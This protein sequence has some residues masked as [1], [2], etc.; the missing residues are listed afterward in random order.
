MTEH[1][2]Y[3]YSSFD[4]DTKTALQI[5]YNNG[6]RKLG[7]YWKNNFK[8]SMQD[9]NAAKQ[10]GFEI[11]VIHGP[12][13]NTADIW[14]YNFKG[15]K[16]YLLLKK[17][18]KQMGKFNIKTLVLHTYDKTQFKPTKLGLKR[19]KNLVKLCKRNNVVLAVENLR[20]I[21]HMEYLLENIN[22]DNFKFCL[23]FGHANVWQLKPM[24]LM[25][26][27][28][29]R[30]HTVHISDNDGE[31]DYHL[32]PGDGTMDWPLLMEELKKHYKGPL[33]LEID[34]FKHPTIKYPDL[35]TYLK[36]AVEGLQM[37][38]QYF[39]K[40][41]VVLVFYFNLRQSLQKNCFSK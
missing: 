1:G 33:M 27:H 14:K 39:K 31:K 29:S 16:Y 37:L 24:Q 6:F 19:F 40:T 38:D 17:Y 10:V 25:Q 23:D 18:I 2:I 15:L 3:F 34:N 4:L 20:T 12:F 41:S 32:V 11:E 30:L 8:Q 9:Y 26:K 13:K 36:R 5:Y 22:D 7:M 35:D 28:G 21:D